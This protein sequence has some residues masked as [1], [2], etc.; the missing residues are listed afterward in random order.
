MTR[1]P[2]LPLVLVPL[3]A[4]LATGPARAQ[5]PA[6]P[7]PARALLDHAEAL[8]DTA[9]RSA[10]PLVERALAALQRRPDAAL[11]AR[12]LAIRC[13]LSASV[14]EPDSLVALAE[15][16]IPRARGPA[17]AR[18]RG[19]L[20]SCRGYGHEMAGR[21]DRAAADYEAAV[22]DG[23]VEANP[24]SLATA[25]MLRGE[26]R[27]YRGDL[28]GA[29]A[30]L[31]EANDLYARTGN[32]VRQRY[33]LN[34]M[35]SV[36]ADRRVGEYDRAL[37]YYGQ[38]LASH[39]AEGNERGESTALF[40]L[41]KTR[42]TKGDFAAALT[43]YRRSLAIERRRGDPVEVAAV[44]RAVGQTYAK[45]GRP[46]EG[47]RW[48]DEAM[49]VSVRAKHAGAVAETRLPRGVALRLLGRPREALREL[50]GALAYF[51]ENGSDRFVE[52]IQDERALAFAA[53]GDT[54]SAYLARMEQLRLQQVLAERAKAELSA[55]LRAQFDSDKKD[56]DNRS[57][58][59][60]NRLRGQA[61]R[62]AERIRRLQTAVTALALATA[63][64]LGVLVL[65]H[66]AAGRRLRAMAMTDDL[67]RVANRR[68]LLA[69]AEVAMRDRPL[70]VLALD[71]DRF[72]AINDTF[73][74]DAGDAVLRRVAE[75]CQGVLRGDHL[76]GRTGGEEFVVLLPHTDAAGGAEVAER[77]RAAVEALA[78][79]DVDPRL[80]VTV[81]VGVAERLPEDDTFGAVLRRADA[82]LYRAKETGRNRV[83]RTAVEA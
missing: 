54:A 42:E 45:L 39:E 16:G 17:D 66:V 33:V 53:A 56:A 79:D 58:R 73:G 3:L 68:A 55:R 25:L 52:R 63:V 75:A 28:G 22:V 70:S 21:A 18:A 57:L 51:E 19:D 37:E 60:E 80:S 9:F 2:R 31:V 35:A 82:S 76:L 64:A 5:Q 36:Y 29:L 46:A 14:V 81:S 40:N 13:W 7:H 15:D 12:A 72:K 23:R 77:L 48:L 47:L 61:L 26:L 43:Y 69:R 11:T 6:A 34:A 71:V 41:G 74:H 50:D 20:H 10:A 49:E 27:H 62:D 44:T 32:A 8:Q 24:R 59:E 65:R 78:W 38:I 4:L 83:E 67:T 30:D 1:R